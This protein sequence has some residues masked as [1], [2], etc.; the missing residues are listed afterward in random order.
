MSTR[1]NIDA[2]LAAKRIAVVGVSRNP[3]DFSRA[4]WTELRKRGYDL[5]PVNPNA[6]EIDGQK[7][8]ARV[9]EIERAVDAAL[10]M[11]SGSVTD[12][13]LRDCVAAGVKRVWFYRASG[14][15]AL[16]PGAVQFCQQNGIEAVPGFC[17]FMFLPHASWFHGI[18]RFFVKL[19]GGYPT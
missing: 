7:C 2:F 12:E 18:H 8:Y 9:S 10:L 15:G 13:T 17:P 5:V 11:T 4:L 19:G 16:T 14:K 1:Q 6:A 3:R